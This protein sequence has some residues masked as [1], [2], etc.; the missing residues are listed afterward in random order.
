MQPP[1][2]DIE[3]YNIGS[4]QNPKMIKFSKT[5][6]PDK[7]LKYIELFKEFHEVFA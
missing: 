4:E 1:N 2:V 3:D 5:F 7:K 6:P